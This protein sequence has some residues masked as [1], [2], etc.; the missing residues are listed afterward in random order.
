MFDNP[1]EYPSRKGG[2]HVN[3][4][5]AAGIGVVSLALVVSAQALP[6]AE[7]K[8]V[9]SPSHLREV[10]I[11]AGPTQTAFYLHNAGYRLV[12][13]RQLIAIVTGGAAW[14]VTWP[15]ANAVR[16]AFA[17]PWSQ[18]TQGHPQGITVAFTAAR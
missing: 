4:R 10:E 15:S 14:N 13:T 18:L 16:I 17:H 2:P 5:V 11:F 9:T 7:T 8:I 1:Y 12:H 3:P 6:R